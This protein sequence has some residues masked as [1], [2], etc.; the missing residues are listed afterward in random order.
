MP[1]TSPTELEQLKEQLFD[2]QTQVAFQED[3]LQA[4]NDIVTR[5]QQQIE[6]L[7][8]LSKS[9]KSQLELMT[10]EMGGAQLD[11]KPPHY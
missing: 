6:N 9:Q 5:Q 10:E 2:L 7:H 11:E 1:V 8:E 3:T 4:L